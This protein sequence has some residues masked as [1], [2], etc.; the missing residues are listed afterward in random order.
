MPQFLHFNLTEPPVHGY[1]CRYTQN[2]KTQ[3]L[4]YFTIS[5]LQAGDIYYCHDDSETESDQFKL[6]VYSQDKV[7][8]QYIALINVSVTL[9]N[10]NEPKLVTADEVL[11]VVKNEQKII[12]REILQYDDVDI[13]TN[14]RDLAFVHVIAT[15]GDLFL[16]NKPSNTFTQADINDHLVHFVHRVPDLNGNVSFVVSDGLHETRGM[17]KVKASDPFIKFTGLKVF[18][19]R[20]KDTLLFDAN[21]VRFDINFDPRPLDIKY[22]VSL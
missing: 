12:S 19:L 17:L 7:A 1:I 5:Q 22:E 11:K 2:F 18:S 14:D 6:L 20:E 15:N 16:S 8:F 3:I 13:T 21:V 10:D 4:L 9:R